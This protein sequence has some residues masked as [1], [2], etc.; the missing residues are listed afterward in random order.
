VK[1]SSE[2]F[3]A[4]VNIDVTKDFEIWS[5]I[6]RLDRKVEPGKYMTN[7]GKILIVNVREDLTFSFVITEKLDR[8]L[9]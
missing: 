2:N 4:E 5:G 7:I 6:G 9:L 8:Y 1:I 3:I